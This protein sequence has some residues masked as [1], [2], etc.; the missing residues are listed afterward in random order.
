ME[1]KFINKSNDQHNG[2]RLFVKY[3]LNRNFL[4]A[5]KYEKH[6]CLALSLE[7]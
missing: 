6:H 2:E 4:G 5:C 3:Q 1:L 7:S